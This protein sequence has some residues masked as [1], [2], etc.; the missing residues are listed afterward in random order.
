MGENIFEVLVYLFD[1]YIAIDK[2]IQAQQQLESELEDVGF[3]PTEIKKAFLWLD[4]LGQLLDIQEGDS[5]PS[6]TAIRVY[7]EDE[8]KKI[9]EEARGFISFIENQS[10]I[11]L[12][13][14]ELIIDRVMA[15]DAG[16]IDLDTMQWIVLFV[17]YHQP[18]REDAYEWLE[19][20]VYGEVKETIH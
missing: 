16:R 10:V 19:D 20:Y 11:D 18:G 12:S 8:C 9:G 3:R 13:L 15:L 17:M 5:I 14:R 1:N 4:E 6:S 7:S 2:K